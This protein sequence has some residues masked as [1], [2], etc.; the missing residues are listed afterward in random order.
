MN[1]SILLPQELIDQIIDEV[2][3]DRASLKACSLISRCWLHRSRWHMHRTITLRHRNYHIHPRNRVKKTVALFSLPAIIAYAQVLHIRGEPSNLCFHKNSEAGDEPAAKAL[4]W[5]TLKKMSHIRTLQVTELYCGDV[6][7]E[8]TQRFRAAL[9]AVTHLSLSDCEFRDPSE[10]RAFLAACP[11]LHTLKLGWIF[12]SHNNGHEWGSRA[13]PVGNAVREAPLSLGRLD[14]LQ[15]GYCARKMDESIVEMFLSMLTPVTITQL[16]LGPTD[17]DIE[18]L[19]AWIRVVGASLQHL[20]LSFGQIAS[21]GVAK[22]GTHVCKVVHPEHDLYSVPDLPV[23]GCLQH[24]RRLQKLTL[25]AKPWNASLRALANPH[26][27]PCA[28]EFLRSAV[29]VDTLHTVEFVWKTNNDNELSIHT[30]EALK[31]LDKLLADS[32]KSKALNVTFACGI[33]SGKTW[34]KAQ[35]L[36]ELLPQATSSVVF[37]YTE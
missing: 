6:S 7:G 8:D 31:D 11:R 4:F 12:W 20:R 35:L 36:S 9:R 22:K 18:M 15:V 30:A 32:C 14:H 3:D 26:F 1:R 16:S 34:Y 10:L 17:L 37:G 5:R 33:R 25:C 24:C 21:L 27:W 13:P 23:S 19:P 29:H 28:L 2:S